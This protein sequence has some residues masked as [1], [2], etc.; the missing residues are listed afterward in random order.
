MKQKTKRLYMVLAGGLCLVAAVA[1]VLTVFKDNLVFFF[2]PSDIE[3]RY[4]EGRTLSPDAKIKVG[5]LVKEGSIKKDEESLLIEFIL[6]DKENDLHVTYEGIAPPMFRDEQGIVAEGFLQNKSNFKATRL[7]TKHDE[8]YMPP[9][10][11]D[12]L[13]KSGQWKGD[14]E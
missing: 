8:N 3:Q 7:L 10:V 11:A 6:T 2:S 9:E 5:G 14:G 4:S 1:I 12:A 13:K